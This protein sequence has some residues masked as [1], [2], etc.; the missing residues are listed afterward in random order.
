MVKNFLFIVA[1]VALLA[2]TGAS[3]TPA[4]KIVAGNSCAASTTTQT[5]SPGGSGVFSVCALNDNASPNDYVCNATYPLVTTDATSAAALIQVTAVSRTAPFVTDL[6]NTPLPSTLS[7]TAVGFSN[8]VVTNVPATGQSSATY[9]KFGELTLFVPSNVAAGTTLNFG[10]GLNRRIGIRNAAVTDCNDLDNSTVSTAVADAPFSIQ[11]PAAAT[12]V[13]FSRSPVSLTFAEG[14]AAQTVAVSCTGTIGTPSPVTLGVASSNTSYFTVSPASLSF[15]DCSTPQNVTVTPRAADAGSNPTQTGTVNFTNTT[16]GGTVTA[17]ASVA[18]T[19]TDN[20]APATYTITKSTAT[21]TEGSATTDTIVVTCNGA[22]VAPA[23]SGSVAYNIATLT[24]PGDITTPALTGTLNFAA[25]G[26]ATQTL[27]VT[28]RPNDALLQGTHTG[29]V[30]ISTPVGGTLGA[31]T[32]GT[33]TVLDSTVAVNAVAGSTGSATSMTITE[34]GIAR[35]SVA[36][37]TLTAAQTVNYSITPATPATGDTFVGGGATG[38]VTCPAAAA[39]LVPIPT[40]VQTIDDTVIGNS[41]VYSVT[42]SLSGNSTGV[43]IGNASAQVLVQDNDQAVVVPTMGAAGLGLM[44]L[45]LAGLAA[46][47][48]RRRG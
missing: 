36:C 39:S 8:G 48:R 42:I 6:A 3:A 12:N 37:P 33:I 45:M 34:G 28:A 16:T 30:T 9:Q 31:T 14:G 35:F 46:L 19:V 43:V 25:C 18:V 40:T 11:V 27:T 17:P 32:S 1:A 2:P 7:A 5:V 20:Q 44:S 22:F 41:R 21:V 29:N 10:L 15:T 24:N 13:T 47:Q 23:T 38:T 26:G 4:F